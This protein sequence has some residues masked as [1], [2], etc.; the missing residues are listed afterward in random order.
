MSWITN[1][2]RLYVCGALVRSGI[3]DII[4]D[5]TPNQQGGGDE[6][7][8]KHYWG[9]P[10]IAGVYT[11]FDGLIDTYST[12]TLQ[13]GDFYTNYLWSSNE[14]PDKDSTVYIRHPIVASTEFTVKN[15][16]FLNHGKSV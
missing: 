8:I 15:L 2:S 9:F 7:I 14:V 10:I 4:Y 5:F 13:S 6:F 3:Q 1:P 11:N 16:I 12:F